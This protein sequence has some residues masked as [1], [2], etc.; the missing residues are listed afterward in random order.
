L[1][2]WGSRANSRVGDALEAAYELGIVHRNF[3][4]ANI[5]AMEC[6]ELRGL[7]CGKGVTH[8]VSES[9]SR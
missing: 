9:I 2:R 3:T 1:G 4:P 5:K 8:F 6:T 7:P